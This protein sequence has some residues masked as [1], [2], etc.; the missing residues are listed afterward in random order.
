MRLKHEFLD[1]MINGPHT[2]GWLIQTGDSGGV[3]QFKHYHMHIQIGPVK[4]QLPLTSIQLL[5][6]EALVTFCARFVLFAPE[7]LGSSMLPRRLRV[8]IACLQPTEPGVIN[9]ALEGDLYESLLTVWWS[10]EDVQVV[11]ANDK[12]A[13]IKTRKLLSG[14]RWES[15]DDYVDFIYAKDVLMVFAIAEDHLQEAIQLARRQRY[16]RK[17]VNT[18]MQYINW[19]SNS[20]LAA[21]LNKSAVHFLLVDLE[22]HT[23]VVRV[24]ESAVERHGNAGAAFA[25]HDELQTLSELLVM[26]DQDSNLQNAYLLSLCFRYTNQFEHA[27]DF[28][29]Q[30]LE[31]SPEDRRLQRER[32]ILKILTNKNLAEEDL[33]EK[34]SEFR[35]YPI[36]QCDRDITLA[37]GARAWRQ[38][39]RENGMTAQDFIM[40]NMRTLRDAKLIPSYS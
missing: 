11:S 10:F 22:I 29:R 28:V 39:S 38:A 18:S 19:Q 32:V 8:R 30:A 1:W 2:K 27:A 23:R 16:L 3:T 20:T 34:G 9:R 33:A 35:R 37:L 24:A 6:H 21:Q 7:V 12:E 15:P 14:D 25:V 36:E 4:K 40:A 26:I 13:A 5:G 17:I 31:N